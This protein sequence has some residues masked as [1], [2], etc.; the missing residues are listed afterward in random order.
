MSFTIMKFDNVLQHMKP[1]IRLN[2]NNKGR[3]FII[4][5]IHGF[6]NDTINLLDNVNFDP[7]V[8]RVFQCGDLTDRGPDSLSCLSLLLNPWFYHVQSNHDIDLVYYYFGILNEQFFL[9]RSE[10]LWIHHHLYSIMHSSLAGEK[11]RGE[12]ADLIQAYI[13]ALAQSPMM[14]R[15]EDS[16]YTIHAELHCDDTEVITD[17]LLTDDEISKRWLHNSSSYAD[18]PSSCGLW[19]RRT[20]GVD[21]TST[22]FKKRADAFQCSPIYSGHTIQSQ[23]MPVR[24][25]SLINCDTGSFLR[26][27]THGVSIINHQTQESWTILNGKIEKT[28]VKNV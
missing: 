9:T 20:W 18:M 14:Y 28:F 11:L 23:G 4:G 25:G 19:S 3:D 22:E 26:D 10:K 16:F 17:D 2:K 13:P 21:L 7:V 1:C 24:R 5:D 8:D 15:V 12:T 27:S 6:Y